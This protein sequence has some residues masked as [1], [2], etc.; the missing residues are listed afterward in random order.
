VR[1]AS[2]VGLE[3]YEVTGAD[4]ITV[5]SHIRHTPLD[6]VGGMPYKGVCPVRVTGKILYFMKN[7]EKI[8][9]II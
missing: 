4:Y 9:I 7:G 2:I 1:R 8:L 5:D 6:T 3:Y